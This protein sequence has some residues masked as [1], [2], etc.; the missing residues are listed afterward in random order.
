[1]I[2]TL[3]ELLIH[4]EKFLKINSAWSQFSTQFLR[5]DKH[6]NYKERLSTSFE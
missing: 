3:I 2:S 5:N 1:M 4:S 6:T